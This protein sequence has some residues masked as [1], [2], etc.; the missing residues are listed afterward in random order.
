[1]RRKRLFPLRV[2]PQSGQRD[3][4]VSHARNPA[5]HNRTALATG[6]SVPLLVPAHFR[7]WNL[8]KPRRNFGRARGGNP[9]GKRR[10]S[11]ILEP[12]ARQR[13]CAVACPRIPRAYSRAK[14]AFN[15]TAWGNAPGI[16]HPRNLPRPERAQVH[17]PN[18]ERGHAH[19]AFRPFRAG[20]PSGTRFGALP[21]AGAFLCRWGSPEAR[22]KC[23]YSSGVQATLD[24]GAALGWGVCTP[25]DPRRAKGA[26][27][28]RSSMGLG[29]TELGGAAGA[30]SRL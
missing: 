7:L 14:D 22:W 9:E 23:N 1:M 5:N 16:R 15:S 19:T 6:R 13:K 21:R 30:D 12:G 26:R 11:G 27:S 2:P 3:L 4:P 18:R 17:H 24:L 20:V 25:V 28:F 10:L 8:R 29:G